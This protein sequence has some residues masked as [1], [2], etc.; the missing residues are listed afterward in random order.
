[1]KLFVTCPRGRTFDSFFDKTNLE[2][3]SS[4][5]D[6]TW[7]P[8]DRNINSEEAAFFAVGA[9]VIMTSWGAPSIDRNILKSAPDLQ[10][11]AHLG[12]ETKYLKNK[13]RAKIKVLSG[14]DFYNR[15]AAEGTLAYILSALR[16]IPEFS[17]RLKYKGEW[18]HKWDSG[19]G[20]MGKTVGLYHC[21]GI[22]EHLARLLMPFGVNVLIYDKRILS[23]ERLKCISAKQVS[24]RELFLKSDIICVYSPTVGDGYHSVGNDLLC[25]VKNGAVFLDV[26]VSGVVDREALLGVL[27]RKNFL[28]VLDVFEKEPPKAN[29]ELLMLSNVIPMPHMAGP[30]PD[31]RR[32]IARKLL[33]ESAEICNSFS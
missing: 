14:E 23:K 13:S 9:D 1:M 26:S 32:I 15:S 5:F 30:T 28:A 10:V 18:K 21:N 24:G 6:V 3:A 20:L 17:L 12:T 27:L 7:N 29:D 8:F 16:S 2:L 31:V 33:L 19:R 25:L 22:A 11:I 4:L